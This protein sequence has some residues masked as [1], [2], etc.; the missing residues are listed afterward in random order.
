MK[1]FGDIKG[2]ICAIQLKS[3][4]LQDTGHG[5]PEIVFLV[6]KRSE[7]LVTIFSG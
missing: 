5:S 1:F 4:T 2:K 7:C 3:V 6:M